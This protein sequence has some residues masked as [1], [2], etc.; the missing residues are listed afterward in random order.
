M[1]CI[2]GQSSA[3]MLFYTASLIGSSWCPLAYVSHRLEVSGDLALFEMSSLCT[4]ENDVI[5]RVEM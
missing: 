2:G 4:I 5:G 1:V 3:L